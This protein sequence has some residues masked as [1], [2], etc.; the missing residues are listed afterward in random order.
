VQRELSAPFYAAFERV[1]GRSWLDSG[2]VENRVIELWRRKDDLAALEVAAVGSALIDVERVDP[3]WVLEIAEKIR[4]DTNGGEHGWIFELIACGMLAAGGMPLRPAPNATRGYDAELT[5]EDGYRLRM[6]FKSFGI[7]D[8]ERDFHL[9][10]SSLR[11]RFRKLLPAGRPMRLSVQGRVHLQH[12]DFAAVAAKL[13]HSSAAKAEEVVPGRV[14]IIV[15]P[16]TQEAEKLPFASGMVSDHCVIISPEHPNE[17]IRRMSRL[18][19]AC[20]NMTEHCPRAP[21]IGNLLL[22]RLHPTVDMARLFEKARQLLE[23]KKQGV[24]AIALYQPSVARDSD[25]KSVLVHTMRVA[26]GPN[27][28]GRGHAL[29]F[30]PLVGLLSSEPSH[31]QLMNGSQEVLK[32]QGNYVYQGGEIF[33]AVKFDGQ[34]AEGELRTLA[35]GVHQ[36]LVI[37]MNDGSFVMQGLFAPHDHLRLL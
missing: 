5:F 17:Q 34:H 25:G 36:K 23:Q 31:V 24:D 7:S 4:V 35:A 20:V 14:A 6:S 29:K 32:L 8:D 27:F 9:R 21:D 1:F 18:H 33:Q 16:L 2:P 22:V 15:R 12:S 3:E 11:E 28:E 13:A 10:A 19:K 26:A 37:E 30:V